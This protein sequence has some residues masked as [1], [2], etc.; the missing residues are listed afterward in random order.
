MTAPGKRGWGCEIHFQFPMVKLI[1][2]ADKIDDLL[3]QTNPFAIIT[4]PI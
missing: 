4:A 1:D 3:E 2:Y